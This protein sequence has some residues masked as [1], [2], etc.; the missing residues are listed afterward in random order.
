MYCSPRKH[1]FLVGRTQASEFLF[2]WEELRQITR[3]FLL[4]GFL[5]H[6]EVLY[7]SN[8]VMHGHFHMR[9]TRNTQHTRDAAWH[10]GCTYSSPLIRGTMVLQSSSITCSNC[11]PAAPVACY[12][13]L[14]PWISPPQNV[15]S[16]DFDPSTESPP[17]SLL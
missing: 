14:M 17:P 5:F 16:I 9:D 2:F 8:P 4:A 10:R 1:A 11:I 3:W 12:M 13:M 7:V 6:G 15:N